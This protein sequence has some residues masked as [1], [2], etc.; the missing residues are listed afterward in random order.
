MYQSTDG[1]SKMYYNTA[2]QSTT[3]KVY[4]QQYAPLEEYYSYTR[5]YDRQYDTVY[6][7]EKD[8]HYGK[9]L[10]YN[11]RYNYRVSQDGVEPVVVKEVNWKL[12][13]S[14][15]GSVVAISAIITLSCLL[16]RITKRKE[17]VSEEESDRVK[18]RR[19]F[20]MRPL[21]S[22]GSKIT[23]VNQAIEVK[24]PRVDQTGRSS[25]ISIQELTEQDLEM[26][27]SQVQQ[28]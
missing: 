25:R 21:P 9:Y 8:D 23:I 7:K 15:V 4:Q 1:F 11:E 27:E 19:Q 17:I 14:L 26:P 6:F 10:E 3:G 20:K 13:V 24:S 18:K 2:T 5:S 16:K 12:I 28:T 22:A